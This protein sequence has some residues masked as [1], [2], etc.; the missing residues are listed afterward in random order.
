MELLDNL[1]IVM[2]APETH[3]DVVRESIGRAGAVKDGDY[4]YC[5]YLVKE[6]GCFMPNKGSNPH[7][8]KE[9]VLEEIKKVHPY[10]KTVIDIYPVCE[11]GRKKVKGG[12]Q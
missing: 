5:S 10:K 12:K 3:A 8:G 4:S 1:T 9:D 7:L 2:T 6:L 11:I